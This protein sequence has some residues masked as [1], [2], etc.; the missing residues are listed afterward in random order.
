MKAVSATMSN[1][2]G[3]DW[4][5]LGA[6]LA[7]PACGNPVH[8][9]AVAALGGER[10]GVP[11]GPL[12]RPGEPCLTCHGEDGPADAR[13]SFAGTVYQ[14]PTGEE[15]ACGATVRVNGADGKGWEVTTNAAGN[16]FVDA[17]D[18][19]G[20]FPATTTV[21]TTFV[22]SVM[23]TAM[24]RSGSCNECHA[25]KPSRTTPGF[26]WVGGASAACE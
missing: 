6:L 9:D 15:K 10:P 18:F 3:L 5:L 8:E 19:P 13:F 25:G 11:K 1:R 26:V 2:S 23:L 16:F 22:E 17:S 7:L 24:N 14:T 12:H 4:A 20:A 21:R